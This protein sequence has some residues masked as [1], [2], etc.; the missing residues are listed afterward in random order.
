MKYLTSIHGDK[1]TVSSLCITLDICKEMDV[2]LKRV[3]VN[4]SLFVNMIEVDNMI[5]TCNILVVSF[6]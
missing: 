3:S 2:T 1:Q 5:C 6:I 4:N